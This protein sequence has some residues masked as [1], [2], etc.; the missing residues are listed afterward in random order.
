MNTGKGSCLPRRGDLAPVSS[1]STSVGSSAVVLKVQQP[2]TK[3]QK[4][5]LD[6]VWNFLFLLFLFPVDPP[7]EV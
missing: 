1:Q 4:P 5:V 7:N 6:F 2:E 3:S